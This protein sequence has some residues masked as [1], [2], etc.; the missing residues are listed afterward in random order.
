MSFFDRHNIPANLLKGEGESQGAF[1]NVIGTLKAFSFVVSTLKSNN[2]NENFIIHRLVQ[3]SIRYWL[4]T[5]KNRA[6]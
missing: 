1:T 6:E 3:V 5:H 4:S 2:S